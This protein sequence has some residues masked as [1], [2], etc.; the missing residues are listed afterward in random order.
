MTSDKVA[1]R[2][3]DISLVANR[4]ACV[5]YEELHKDPK[6][7]HQ[8]YTSDSR[9]TRRTENEDLKI[10]K[11]QKEIY[12]ILE[13]TSY[14]KIHVDHVDSQEAPNN[15]VLIIVTGQMKRRECPYMEDFVQTFF[16]GSQERLNDGKPR[17][18]V[19]NDMLQ[20]ISREKHSVKK[21]S[22]EVKELASGKTNEATQKKASSAPEVA[23]K[24]E[25]TE[26]K[27]EQQQQAHQV[28]LE[29]KV[30]AEVVANEKK[31]PQVKRSAVK[32]KKGKKA[33]KGASE[34]NSVPSEST[35]EVNKSTETST[36]KKN[37]Q[38]VQN[39]T[40]NG[41]AE[42]SGT[43]V[44]A[45]ESKA[46]NEVSAPGKGA[47]WKTWAE[48]FKS[49][50]PQIEPSAAALQDGQTKASASE[51]TTKTSDKQNNEARKL[52]ESGVSP[53]E[54]Q[55][56][57]SIAT[58]GR[59]KKGGR[60]GKSGRYIYND[61]EQI[62]K[63]LYVNNLPSCDKADIEAKFGEFGKIVSIERPHLVY[64]FVHYQEREAVEAA[65]KARPIKLGGEELKVDKRR[66]SNRNKGPD[67]SRSRG[68]RARGGRYRHAGRGGDPKRS[69]SG[70]KRGGK[71]R[72]GRA[73]M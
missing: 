54:G 23:P 20:F 52:E 67:A 62:A 30:K 56:G 72:G 40:S 36:V 3:V 35:P 12:K 2:E 17:F 58:R 69:D 33:A 13:T 37:A 38:K 28:E 60:G 55:S 73:H 66:P 68:G 63:T 16:L 65:L 53:A 15:G 4:F 42:E 1:D 46:A 31:G 25:N 6:R 8:F 29:Y 41:H 44:G 18:Y 51:K 21:P 32:N 11:G 49:A 26:P 48:R 27:K 45:G 43:E 5:Y 10:A 22:Q 39:I 47:G 14:D 57:P 59:G 61:P 24:A 50:V 64:C 7:T 34:E 9:F 70:V 71:G 19:C